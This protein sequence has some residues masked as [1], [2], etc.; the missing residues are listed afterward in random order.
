[1][2]ATHF[3]LKGK[4]LFLAGHGGV[5]GQA[6]LRRLAAER[7]DVVTVDRSTLDLRRQR[8][9]ETWF[10]DVRPDA[11]VLCAARVGGIAAN[12]RY[13]A[14][15]LYDNLSIETNVIHAAHLAGV[16]R[17]LFLGASCMYPRL[18]EQPM[19][20]ESI[21]G[22]PLEPTNE[23]Y[24]VAKIAGLKLCQAYRRQHQRDYIV[25]IPANLF[26]PGDDIDLATSHVVS[27]LIRKM[28]EAKRTDGVVE[29]WGTGR[30]RREFLYVDDAADA[31]VLLLRHYSSHEPINV[32]GGDDVSVRELVELIREVVGFNGEVRYDTSRPDGMPIK[33]L[34]TRRL[35]GLLGWRP[36]HGLREGLERT[37]VWFLEHDQI[38]RAARE[39][40]IG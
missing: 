30:A 33:R 8:E 34:D 15:F 11:V 25:A 4:R 7:C 38:G 24:A 3:S 28:H 5:V 12:D 36:K 35:K 27:A 1:V 18:A 39:R 29:V 10:K 32:G 9:V 14:D 17:L 13:P 2:P 20:E 37:Y 22:G 26:G 31:L 16:S 19:R 21:L 6:L 40:A 23:W